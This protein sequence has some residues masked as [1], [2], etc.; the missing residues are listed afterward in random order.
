MIISFYLFRSFKPFESSNRSKVGEHP[1]IDSKIVV[2]GK[3]KDLLGE[4]TIRAARPS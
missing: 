4:Q 3:S 1:S 2:G